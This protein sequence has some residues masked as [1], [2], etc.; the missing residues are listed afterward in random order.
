V[1][2]TPQ[3]AV[4]SLTNG[5][6]FRAIVEYNAGCFDT[7]GYNV[8]IANPNPLLELF[9]DSSTINQTDTVL[10]WAL[11]LGF[12]D[13][14]WQLSGNALWQSQSGDEI[15]AALNQTTLFTLSVIDE[16]GCT[17]TDTL[18]V[19]V[20]PSI[21]EEPY[22]FIPNGFTPN[23]DGQNDTWLVYGAALSTL[24]VRVYD[25]WGR[26]VFSSTD[27]NTGWDG[28]LQGTPLA[29]DVYAYHLTAECIGGT[30]ITR[31][32]NISLIR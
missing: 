12:A 31:Q 23:N 5:T 15:R 6:E 17:A 9:A 29:P 19:H 1:A 8:V 32:G 21:C 11:P 27:L 30:R 24:E 14:S 16:N 10:V 7:I 20:R 28:T 22:L 4:A 13:Y 3:Q 18:T 2:Q 25:R 26:E